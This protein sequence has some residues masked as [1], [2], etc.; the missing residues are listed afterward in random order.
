MQGTLSTPHSTDPKHP[1][2]T[3]SPVLGK[4]IHPLTSSKEELGTS[5][6]AVLRASTGKLQ[7]PPEAPDPHHQVQEDRTE[8]EEGVEEM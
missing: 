5:D 4:H 6:V 2:G 3:A 7:H 1:R 8:G